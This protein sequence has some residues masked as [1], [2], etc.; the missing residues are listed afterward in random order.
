MLSPIS[1]SIPKVKIVTS[2]PTKTKVCASIIPGRLDTY[3]FDTECDYYDEYRKS[4]FAITT[5]KGG[6]D[7]MRHY[8]IL[9][10][11][12]IPYF[13]NIE[14][15]PPNT[16]TFLPKNIILTSNLLYNNL[17]EKTFDELSANEI[18]DCKTIISTLLEF[19]QKHLSTSSMALYLVK[20][21]NK[22]VNTILYLS[23]D[24]GPDYLRCLTL[25]GL[26]ELFGCQCHDYPKIPHIYKSNDID[27]KKLYGKGITYTNLLNPELHNKDLDSSLMKDITEK[28]YDVIIYG[29][30]HRGLPYYDTISSIYSPEKIILL[31]GEDLHDCN[32]K[33][34]IE[35]G[36]N[37][38]VREL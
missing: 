11:G 19:T 26:K 27:Y 1:F 12:C 29:S 10:N 18:N 25:I 8:E 38:F 9:A 7:C 22:P 32:Y 33:Y 13:P 20:K 14:S 17:K 4:L 16:M 5:K 34:W 28:K 21:Y 35:K 15:C 2:I 37:V 24:I 30:L 23:E 3:T 36:H 31:C 6:W